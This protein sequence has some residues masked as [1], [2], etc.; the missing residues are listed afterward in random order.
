MKSLK[1]QLIA[2]MLLVV[3]IPFIL[4][5]ITGYF[6]IGKHYQKEIEENNKIFATT[7]ADHVQSFIDKA[8]ALTEEIAHNND[9]KSFIP[10]K[11]RAVLLDNIK[12]NPYF[13]LLYIQGTDGMQTAKTKGTLGNRSERF[14]FVKFMKDKKPFVSKSYPTVLGN[15]TV[16]VTSIIL[17]I[18]DENDDLKGI[19][20]SDLK[21]DCI[22]DMVEK[23]S[24]GDDKYAYVLDGKG[25]VIAHPDKKQVEELYNYKTFEKTVVVKDNSGNAVLDEQGNQKMKTEAIQ[26]PNKLKEITEKA[27]KGESGVAEYTDNN[28]EVVISAYTSIELPGH[29][30]A[31]A[32]ITVQKK[33]K[34]MAFVTDVHKINIFIGL[35]LM[36]LVA[37]IAYVIS[38]RI[39]KPIA[40]MMKLMETA[41]DG[42]L[43]VVSNI[44]AKN[45]VGKLSES[46][47]KMINGMKELLKRIKD[48]SNSVEK[49]SELLSMTT[50]QSAVAID[51]VARTIEE[52]ANGA[53]EQAKEAEEGV[54]AAAELAKEIENIAEQL[55]ISQSYADEVYNIN[56][57]GLDAIKRLQDKTFESNEA[58]RQVA[59]VVNSLTNKTK[60]IDNIVETI[61]SIAEQT[62]LLALNAA[63]EAARAGDAGRG[64]AVVAEEVRELAE[65]TGNSSNNVREIIT[66]IQK[67]VMLA[68]KTMELSEELVKDQNAAIHHV[69]QIAEQI[70]RAV[71]SIVERIHALAKS[72]EN[73]SDSKE[74]VLSVIENVSA[75]SEETA[76][77][78]QEVSASTQEQT[79]SMQQLSSLAE[80]LDQ[81]AKELEKT[82]KIF[83]LN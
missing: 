69:Q 6:F 68:Q 65:S 74:R 27:L 21:L 24:V 60:A 2:I 28:G 31:W 9:V 48:L 46:F 59:E 71:G 79:A 50:E 25:V 15:G 4:S 29:S 66:T 43:T 19:M 41:A 77:A 52:V 22:Q 37:F 49:S 42:D 7:V 20:G 80:E 81:M 11:Q 44:K 3:I 54:Q 61:M 55:K 5:N 17:P 56:N 36:L 35:V 63:I 73:I 57:K 45:E 23:F 62:N 58:S 53:N 39:T 13:D 14:W 33:E 10:E 51:E 70:A 75:V 78:S 34:A 47:N 12:R 38:N 64:F 18:Y 40:N 8:Y 67:D 16:P 76:A 72:A 26:I 82:I 83:K 32:V 30:D 1:H